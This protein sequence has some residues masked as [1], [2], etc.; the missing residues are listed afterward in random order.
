[1][2]DGAVARREALA[3]EV[4][5][6]AGA[7]VLLVAGHHGEGEQPTRERLFGGPELGVD[8]TEVVLRAEEDARPVGPPLEQRGDLSAAPPDFVEHGSRVAGE[9][10]L[11]VALRVALA[12]LVRERDGERAAAVAALV[13]REARP[14]REDDP[15]RP[16]L[17]RASLRRVGVR[18]P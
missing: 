14:R 2:H 10:V 4:A 16:G 6:Y 15:I 13:A 17:H 7:R 8:L 18:P 9:D 3:G 12:L 11:P 5:A 1:R